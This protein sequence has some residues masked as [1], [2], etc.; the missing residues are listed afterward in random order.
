MICFS[1]QFSTFTEKT[2]FISFDSG[3]KNQ[4]LEQIEHNENEMTFMETTANEIHDYLENII[5]FQTH[6]KLVSG[7]CS[8]KNQFW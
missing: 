2:I 4:I 6:Y 8:K 3:K 1:N 5:D 7:F